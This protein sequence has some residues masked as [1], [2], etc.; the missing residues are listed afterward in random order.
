[1]ELQLGDCDARINMDDSNRSVV[2]DYLWGENIQ[3][4]L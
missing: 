3:K 4:Y 1:M 2:E